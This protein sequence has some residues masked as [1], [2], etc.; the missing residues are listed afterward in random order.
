MTNVLIFFLCN[1]LGMFLSLYILCVIRRCKLW[2]PLPKNRKNKEPYRISYDNNNSGYIRDTQ[3]IFNRRAEQQKIYSPPPKINIYARIFNYLVYPI[4]HN[5]Q[6][7]KEK[8]TREYIHADNISHTKTDN[9][10]DESEPISRI[11]RTS[12][13][14][15][16]SI[17]RSPKGTLIFNIFS[18]PQID[19]PG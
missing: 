14:V 11:D 7:Y 2:E 16:I 10:H 1:A 8:N 4:I 19:L 15:R 5:D 3:S 9:N 6:K 17:I 12:R 18:F 13:I